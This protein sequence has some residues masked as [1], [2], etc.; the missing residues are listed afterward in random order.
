MPE[1]YAR[2]VGTSIA[3]LISTIFNINTVAPII[4]TQKA[5]PYIKQTKGSIV[6][7]SSLAALRG[8][9]VISIY[10]AAKMALTAISQS[11]AI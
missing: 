2:K 5:L 10:S 1:F 4:L 3:G 7:I 6:F 11:F 8:L 9:P